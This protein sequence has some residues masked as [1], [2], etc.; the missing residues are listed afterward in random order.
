MRKMKEAKK[1]GLVYEYQP[2]K[3]RMKHIREILALLSIMSK[4]YRF[5]EIFN[6]TISTEEE[7]NMCELLD[8]IEAKGEAIGKITALKTLM[9]NMNIS[10]EQAMQLLSISKEDYAKYEAVLA[11]N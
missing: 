7:T 2:S 9:N 10:I 4:D 11:Q 8:Q 5:E 3:Q 6:G 1:K